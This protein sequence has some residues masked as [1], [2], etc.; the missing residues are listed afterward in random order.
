[1][2]WN[3]AKTYSKTLSDRFTV[4]TERNIKILVLMDRL[5]TFTCRISCSFF[6]VTDD[7][8]LSQ[9]LTLFGFI[10]ISS[11]HCCATTTI[12]MALKKDTSQSRIVYKGPEEIRHDNNQYWLFY[13]LKYPLNKYLDRQYR[14][15][16]NSSN[17][18]KIFSS[19]RL[20][21]IF[22]LYLQLPIT[23]NTYKTNRF[24]SFQ[25]FFFR[26]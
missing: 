9:V 19:F 25:H 21:S 6:W 14:N 15:F 13:L 12:E 5:K 8:D 26:F 3:P 2:L 23:R 17:D 16:N 4:K 11:S 22:S 20:N 18:R 24:L 10:S 7:R 1:M